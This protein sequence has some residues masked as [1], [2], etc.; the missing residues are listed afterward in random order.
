MTIKTQ[1]VPRSARP[2]AP[3]PTMSIT[4]RLDGLSDVV[5]TLSKPPKNIEL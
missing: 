2:R 5:G 3:C 4:I 1:G